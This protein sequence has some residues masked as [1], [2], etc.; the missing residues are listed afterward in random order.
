MKAVF[1]ARFR[2]VVFISLRYEDKGEI[3]EVAGEMI[4]IASSLR[5]SQ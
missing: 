5:S 2:K 3:V 4:E 1:Q